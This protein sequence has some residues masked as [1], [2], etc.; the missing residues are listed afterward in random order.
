MKKPTRKELISALRGKLPRY[1]RSDDKG[2]DVV[3]QT[4][5]LDLAIR[6]MEGME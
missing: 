4:S 5:E 2:E 3:I 6:Y 1:H